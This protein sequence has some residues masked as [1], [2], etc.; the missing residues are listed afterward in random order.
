MVDSELTVNIFKEYL[1]LYIHWDYCDLKFS[2]IMMLS[3][4]SHEAVIK[5]MSH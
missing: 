4:F 2:H 3:C 1:S 5:E